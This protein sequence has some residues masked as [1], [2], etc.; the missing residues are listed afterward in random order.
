MEIV[1]LF[2]AVVGADF[3]GRP[4]D[5]LRVRADRLLSVALANGDD[6]LVALAVAARPAHLKDSG[7]PEPFGD[8][9]TGCLAHAVAMLEELSLTAA[10]RGSTGLQLPAAY[11][12]CAQAYR[13]HELWELEVEMYD[14]AESSL[15]ALAEQF[16]PSAGQAVHE[17]ARP[18]LDL[19]R[20]VLSFN[21]L[22]ATTSLVCGFLEIGRREAAREVAVSRQRLTPQ[23]RAHLPTSWASE[24]LAMD[25]LLAVVAG[26]TAGIEDPRAVP[27]GL[28]AAVADAGWGGY[29]ACLL[30]AAALACWDAGDLTSAASLGARAVDLLDDFR[31]SLHTW[32][33]R[34]A[35][36]ESASDTAVHYAEHLAMLRWDSRL[37]VLMAA[38]SRL[39]AARV[40]RQGE[41]LHRQAWVDELTGLANRHA[42][43]RHLEMLRRSDPGD[44]LTVTLLDVDHFK[45]VN[46]TFGHPLGDEVL[47]TVGRM[48]AGVVRITDLA[49]RLGGDEFALLVRIGADADIAGRV[50]SIVETVRDHDW[51]DLAAGL[52]VTVSAGLAVGAA[53]D[54]D[55]LLQVADGNL[56]RAKAAGRNQSAT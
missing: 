49:V 6:V 22:E 7:E 2:S 24:A 44:R 38:R 21:R 48:L 18:V 23:Q 39:S 20:E 16:G 54:V 14:R 46:D 43:T 30:L 34:M 31:P 35:S 4:P 37:H 11:V 17:A 51:G 33:L 52:R 13:R 53:L 36:L 55:R 5:E 29:P 15:S 27:A 50:G 45:A 40:L 10:H 28:Y 9:L 3:H 32:A 25:R 26:E 47:R 1:L 56:Y 41:L 42:Y 8:D 19:N 12:E